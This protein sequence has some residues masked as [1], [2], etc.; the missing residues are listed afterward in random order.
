MP[1]PQIRTVKRFEGSLAV[2]RTRVRTDAGLEGAKEGVLAMLALGQAKP[3]GSGAVVWIRYDGALPAEGYTVAAGSDGIVVETGGVAGAVYAAATLSQM[4]AENDGAL[5]FCRIE[6]EPRFAW[7]GFLLDVCRHFFPMETV[8]RLVDLLAYDKFNRLHLHLSDDQGFRFESERF[9]LLNSVGSWRE[10]TLIKHGGKAYQDGLPHGGYY[11]KEELRALVQYAKARGV[12]IIPE[13][14]MPGHALSVMAAYPEL[15]CFPEPTKVATR[16]GVT[17]FS[18]KLYCAGSEKTYDFLFALLDEVM[19]VFPFEY[20]H[21]GGDEAVKADW[22]RCGK[23]QTVRREQGLKD[24]R[25]LQGY[26]LNRVIGHIESRGRRAVVWNDGLCRTLTD[27]AVVQYWTPLSREGAAQIARYINAGGAAIL[28]PVT[29]LYFDYPYAATPLAKTYRYRPSLHGIRRGN[30]SRILGVEAALWTEWVDTEE[31]LFFNILPR[32]A[33]T[34]ETGWTARGGKRYSDFLK[35]L[36]PH[37]ALYDR[38]G[39]TYAKRAEVPVPPWK[40]VGGLA[41]FIG[42]ETHAEL[43]EQLKNGTNAPRS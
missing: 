2:D 28:S 29:R 38:L 18:K 10:S 30:E 13:F 20:V 4:L 34:A 11:T 32:L 42:G 15:A 6:D 7:R 1:I 23:C 35:R 40:R 3:E 21:I 14:D 24:E 8:R 33:A 41:T 9:P 25:E 16:F 26:F 5:P 22:K 43:L 27:S 12:E 37:Y 17:D 19:D 36:K 31:K 39:L